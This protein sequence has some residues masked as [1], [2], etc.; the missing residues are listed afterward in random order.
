MP[1]LIFDEGVGFPSCNRELDVVPVNT[2]DANGFY[3]YLDLPP[4]A[5]SRE[6]R[7]RCRWLL[8]K[9][10]PDGR[11]PNQERFRRVVEIYRVLSDAYQKSL[12]DHTP[13]DSLFLDDYEVM[14]QLREKADTFEALKNLTTSLPKT[15]WSY[16]VY[17]P[18]VA[19]KDDRA[20]AQSWYDALVPAA[21]VRG[22][23]GTIQLVLSDL[24]RTFFEEG[25]LV[26]VPR[27]PPDWMAVERLLNGCRFLSHPAVMFTSSESFAHTSHG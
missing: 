5:T 4:W 23:R 9:Y 26:S 25:G 12:Y 21:Y 22:Y 20:L 10:H 7:T 19:P 3:E 13:P 11:S 17:G 24:L 16:H 8:R 2:N 18:A 15:H 1:E 14:E 6:I 27:V